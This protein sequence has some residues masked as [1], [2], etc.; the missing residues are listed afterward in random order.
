V[1][2]VIS[3]TA[4]LPCG[5]LYFVWRFESQ[6]T[7]DEVAEATAASAAEDLRAAL[8]GEEACALRRTLHLN[9]AACA[10]KRTDWHLARE[11]AMAVL[12]EEAEHPKALYR[13]AQAHNGAGELAEGVR[14]LVRL[15]KVE[16]QQD[17]RDARRLLAELKGRREQE[18][19]MFSGVCNKQGFAMSDVEVAAVV[20]RDEQAKRLKPKSALEARFDAYAEYEKRR[21]VGFKWEKRS[22]APEGDSAG[23]EVLNA[24]LAAQLRCRDRDKPE[25]F[26][27]VELDQMGVPKDL[28][29][30]DWI[31]VDGQCFQPRHR[32][33]FADETEPNTEP[34][35]IEMGAAD[36]AED[37]S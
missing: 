18:K 6:P 4:L 25:E 1:M 3:L 31:M 33:W 11:A 17:N 26:S 27:W 36:G 2:G 16:G 34:K 23:K 7:E 37:A 19:A 20:A 8:K 12:V 5:A 10:L 29:A 14:V 30:D 22:A 9:V 15:L 28:T 32:D 24:A 21:K 35:A 13:L